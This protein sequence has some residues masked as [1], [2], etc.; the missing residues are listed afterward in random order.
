MNDLKEIYDRMRTKRDEKKKVNEVFRDVLAQSTP[1][2]EVLDELKAVKIKKVQIE[3]ELR[4]QFSQEMEQLERL[5]LDLKTDAEMLSDM[6]LTKLMKGETIEIVD[7]NDTKFEPV[8]K[9]TFK[10][11]L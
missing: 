3:T 4:G 6:A 11:A 9:V 7:E 10:K 8:F 2:Q 1:Y 5:T